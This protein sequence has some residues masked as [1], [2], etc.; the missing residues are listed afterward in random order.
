MLEDGEFKGLSQPDQAV[1]GCTAY[2]TKTHDGGPLYSYFLWS[3]FQTSCLERER[4]N[5][6]FQ[7]PCYF[8]K[9]QQQQQRTVEW[10]SSTVGTYYLSRSGSGQLAAGALCSNVPL[11]NEDLLDLFS[12]QRPCPACYFRLWRGR[13]WQ[14]SPPTAWC[15]CCQNGSVSLPDTSEI[16]A[17]KR[18]WLIESLAQSSNTQLL[19]G[20]EMWKIVGCHCLCVCFTPS[21]MKTMWWALF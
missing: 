11:K 3:F 2:V 8:L 12:W 10:C 9:Q 7:L 21:L 4:C 15:Q 6:Q 13:S 20:N 5:S 14:N 18:D 19:L 17:L 16:T 1:S